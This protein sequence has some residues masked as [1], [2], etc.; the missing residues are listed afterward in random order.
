M[1]ITIS[2]PG[3]GSDPIIRTYTASGTWTKPLGQSFYGVYVG[4]VGGGAGAPSGAVGTGSAGISALVPGNSG[5]GGAIVWSFIPTSTLPSSVTI[6]VGSGGSGG[7]NNSTTYSNASGGSGGGRTTFGNFVTASGADTPGQGPFNSNSGGGQSGF[8]AGQLFASYPQNFPLC[9]GGGAP[10]GYG[11]S[12]TMTGNDGG[13]NS[14][15]TA[16]GGSGGTTSGSI[17][18]NAGRGGRMYNLGVISADPTGGTGGTGQ[19]GSNGIN[20]YNVNWFIDPTVSL[21]LGPGS[22]GG[23]GGAGDL[24]GTIAGGN[25]GNG[26]IGAGGGTGGSSRSGVK[27]GNGGRGGDG[28]CVVIEIYG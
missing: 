25:G 5:G 19:T 15:G 6:T 17:V 18:R 20:S 2:S 10:T 7:V 1:G 24:N 27:A 13:N 4:C 23:G 22:G 11:V 28:L 21:P 12:I 8:Q 3:Y 9:M 26:G 14:W 16:A